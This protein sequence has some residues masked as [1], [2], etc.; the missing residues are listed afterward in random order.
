MKNKIEQNEKGIQIKV[1]S[2]LY[3][4]VRQYCSSNLYPLESSEEIEK[5]ASIEDKSMYIKNKMRNMIFALTGL[6]NMTRKELEGYFSAREAFL[7]VRICY[8]G[9]FHVKRI[10]PKLLIIMKLEDSLKYEPTAF[11]EEDIEIAKT[12]KEKLQALTTFQAYTIMM[13]A[14]SFKGKQNFTIDDVGEAFLA[15]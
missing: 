10:N 8:N 1:D 5:M 2:L 9:L 4:T 7:L 11:T 15:A 13:L 3:E 12:L 14:C 6:F